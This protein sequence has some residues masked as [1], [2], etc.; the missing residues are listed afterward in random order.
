MQMANVP[1][2]R[3]VLSN[4]AN[5][6]APSISFADEYVFISTFASYKSGA[7]V[8]YFVFLHRILVDKLG[9]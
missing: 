5:T 3:I 9:F 1:L 4:I 6:I 2:T 8:S 7:I